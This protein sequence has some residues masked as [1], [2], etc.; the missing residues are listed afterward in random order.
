MRGEKTNRI[1]F[2]NRQIRKATTSLISR[3]RKNR[4]EGRR[5]KRSETQT[6]PVL[7]LE[8]ISGECEYLNKTHSDV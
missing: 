1:R 2:K 4:R 8:C 5:E 6:Q 7:L 3:R